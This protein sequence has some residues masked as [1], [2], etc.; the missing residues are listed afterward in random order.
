MPRANI[1]VHFTRQSQ[2]DS[3]LLALPAVTEVIAKLRDLGRDGRGIPLKD[4]AS[5][6]SA[7]HSHLE[8]LI[9]RNEIIQAPGTRSH[10]T[11]E[12]ALSLVPK[13]LPRILGWRPVTTIS[14]ELGIHRNTVESLI[15][16]QGKPEMLRLCRDN[17]LYISQNGET[18]IRE[19]KRELD[20]LEHLE[21]LGDFA[22][23]LNTPLNHLTA[24]FSARQSPFPLDIHGRARLSEEQKR[25]FLEHRARLEQ[26]RRQEDMVLD[27]ELFR[28]IAQVGY[29]QA[30]LFS[31]PG[32]EPHKVISTK[33]TSIVRHFA[34][35]TGLA[36]KTELGVYVPAK[37]A[38]LI[39]DS[40]NLTDASRSLGVTKELIR[41]WRKHNKALAPPTF[42]GMR[43]RGV[44]LSGLVEVA[45][46]QFLDDPTL[47]KLDHVPTVLSSF[48]IT[49]EA[50][51][52]GTSF[53]RI[54]ENLPVPSSDREILENRVGALARSS[55]EIISAILS[56]AVGQ[57][58]LVPVPQEA[59]DRL[60]QN[61][62]RLR[63][64][65]SEFLQVALSPK[66]STRC[67]TD[68]KPLK[69]PALRY[70]VLL[71]LG[72]IEPEVF[73]NTSFI[74]SANLQETLTGWCTDNKVHFRTALS[75]LDL[76][77]EERTNLTQGKGYLSGKSILKAVALMRLTG[78]DARQQYPVQFVNGPRFEGA[79]IRPS[80]PASWGKNWGGTPLLHTTE[81]LTAL[82]SDQGKARPDLKDTC[83]SPTLVSNLINQVARTRAIDPH[84]VYA[85]ARE[86]FQPYSP[87][88][89]TYSDFMRLVSEQPAPLGFAAVIGKCLL[90]ISDPQVM[91]Y[92]YGISRKIANVGDL[93]VHSTMHDYG[94]V[95]RLEQVDGGMIAIVDMI[96]QKK[97]FSFRVG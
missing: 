1:E 18:F 64:S 55:H 59:F 66:L 62:T 2:W 45:R 93:L 34:E 33:A 5:L 51:T 65:N 26:R 6:V 87:W 86:L 7:K 48:T 69:I 80:T 11:T 77:S 60:L 17:C 14:E 97:S 96:V 90:E 95:K 35:Q 63:L 41:S 91:L 16:L 94:F 82:L 88:P 53:T 52:L 23:R 49:S 13:F 15:R 75:I 22:K 81:E 73:P 68:N 70:R 40:L 19:R 71:Q 37:A 78:D 10:I 32:S 21:P 47:S 46:R 12:S 3:Q 44:R 30:S 84:K 43:T 20:S 8:T 50:K 85:F 67:A 29:E 28:S 31:R 76:P 36:R 38:A 72:L 79:S 83:L 92:P 61:A 27:G 56:P 57:R 25:L 58:L 74:P 54:V 89:S 39:A 4:V 24:F 9:E 42:P